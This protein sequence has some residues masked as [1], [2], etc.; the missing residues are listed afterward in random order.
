M[1]IVALMTHLGRLP[2]PMSRS[3]GRITGDAASVRRKPQHLRSDRLTKDYTTDIMASERQAAID[4]ATE[5]PTVAFS[6]AFDM[7]ATHA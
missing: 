4:R 6:G 3:A 1:L 5:A 2:R 7:L